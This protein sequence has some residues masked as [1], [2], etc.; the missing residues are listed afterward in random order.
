MIIQVGQYINRMVCSVR[1]DNRD[2]MLM[3]ADVDNLLSLN[4]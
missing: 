3:Y 4:N 2:T 1:D